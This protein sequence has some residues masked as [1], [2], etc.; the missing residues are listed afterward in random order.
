MSTLVTN[1]LFAQPGRGDDVANLLL[2]IL[3]ESLQW[4]GCETIRIV[5][6]QDDPDHVAGFT[7]WTERR[8]F[9]DYL[10]W[11]TERG[12]SDTFLAMMTRPFVIHYYDTAFFDQ[13]VAARR[14]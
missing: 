3:G 6:D 12:F 4:D 1:E 11:R 2:E 5:R 9:D 10:A 14:R 8:N 7:E 13:G